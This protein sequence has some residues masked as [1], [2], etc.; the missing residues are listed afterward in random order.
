MR[1]Y[2]SRGTHIKR[3]EV[4]YLFIDFSVVK[5]GLFGTDKIYANAETAETG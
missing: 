2:S 4:Q 1:P 3:V 5:L